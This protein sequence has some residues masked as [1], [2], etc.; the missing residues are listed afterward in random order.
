VSA[1]GNRYVFADKELFT[2]TTVSDSK[3][4][5]DTADISGDYT[6]A[7]PATSGVFLYDDPAV[8]VT[9]APSIASTGAGVSASVAASPYTITAS[10]GTLSAPSYAEFAFDNAG[11]LTVTARP[12]TVTYTADAA[13]NVYGG[14]PSNLSGSYALT[15]GNLV[16]GD[17]LGGTVGFTTTADATSGVGSYGITG[18]G[19]IANGNYN[20]TSAQANSNA[21]ALSITARPITV[22]YTADVAQSVYGDTPSGLTGS[23]ALTSGSLVNGDSLA[24]TAI[25]TTTAGETSNV[26]FYDITGSGITASANYSLTST[27]A[28]GNATALSITVLPPK[29]NEIANAPGYW[30]ALRAAFEESRTTLPDLEPLLNLLSGFDEKLACLMFGCR[31]AQSAQIML[32]A[33][34][35]RQVAER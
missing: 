31:P 27:Q 30:A 8:L 22:T 13:S 9:G 3:T 6:I 1:S 33:D 23:Y 16:N 26:G 18:S 25:F 24:G 14:T 32:H 20:L 10:L 2:V 7:A 17:S 35:D 15:S 34:S 12:I 11:E 19:L 5:G 21:G 4:Y 29:T 28:A